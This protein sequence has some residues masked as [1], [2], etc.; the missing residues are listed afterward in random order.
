MQIILYS[1]F[2]SLPFDIKINSSLQQIRI[3]QQREGLPF[4]SERIVHDTPCC[5]P[6]NR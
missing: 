5:H 6:K 1:T 2:H 4:I 3:T